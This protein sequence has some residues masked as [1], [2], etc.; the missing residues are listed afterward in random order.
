MESH[1]QGS[2][3][4]APR[5]FGLAGLLSFFVA[6]AVYLGLLTITIGSTGTLAD[7]D[8]SFPRRL[9][10]TI[11]ISWGGLLALYC[12]WEL[13]PALVVHLV[14]PIVCGVL[15]VVAFLLSVV[16][17]PRME[18]VQVFF[19]VLLDGPFISVLFGFPVVVVMLIYR[20][21]KRD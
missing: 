18:F 2:P 20:V 1:S 9:I 10:A 15:A 6:S 14:G 16:A 3:Q 11:V 12:Y 7:L 17:S 19:V 5:Q 21:L 13:K 4:Y 8:R